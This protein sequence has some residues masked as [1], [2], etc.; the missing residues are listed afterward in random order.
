VVLYGFKIVI[1]KKIQ[2][3]IKLWKGSKFTFYNATKIH[4]FHFRC[5]LSHIGFHNVRMYVL[6]RFFPSQ[7]RWMP[8][9]IHNDPRHWKEIRLHSLGEKGAFFTN[10]FLITC[11]PWLCINYKIIFILKNSMGMAWHLKQ[12][13]LFTNFGKS[14]TLAINGD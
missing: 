10:Q 4:I 12:V 14:I 7:M 1:T 13:E 8:P 2:L 9:P 6:F 11:H 3:Q 5:D